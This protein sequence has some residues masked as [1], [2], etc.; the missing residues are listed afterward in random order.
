[1]WALYNILFSIG[2]LLMVPHFLMRMRRR[3]GYKAHFCN[4]F[5]RYAP[6]QMDAFAPGEQI[7]VHAVSVGEMLVALRFVE[8]W[9]VNEA[10][11]RFVLST[12]TS[13]GHALAQERKDS[14]DVL[15]YYPVDFPLYVRRALTLIQPRALILVENEMW[16]NMVRTSHRRKIP[17]YLINGRISDRSFR[18][19][20][21]ARWFVS[22]MLPL[23]KTLYVQS[24]DDSQRLALL[25]APA[26][27]LR[28]VGSVKYDNASTE[29]SMPQEIQSCLNALGMGDPSQVIVGGSTWPG[30]ERALVEAFVG[31]RKEFPEVKLILVPRHMEKADAVMQDLAPFQLT[32]VRRTSLTESGVMSEA[33]VLVVDTT[34]ELMSFY[35]A[36]DVVFVG[37]SLTE[38]GGQ[39]PIEPAALG[40]AVVVGPNMDNFRAVMT[41]LLRANAVMCVKSI[42]EL[43]EVLGNLI[44]D[45]E[46]RHGYGARARALVVEKRG[47]IQLTVKEI[48]TELS[49][50]A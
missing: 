10:D 21:K 35:G 11:A 47:A 38:S 3:G 14:R 19:Y 5:G 6:E 31:L 32:I 24:A 45:P 37:K 34:G 8:E 1:M 33:D 36:G 26:E 48:A 16:P 42:V 28:E 50:S 39:N 27:S 49:A 44:R 23:V 41:D 17:V 22:R 18:G 13:T 7:W 40:R 30:E 12:N 25:G 43:E 15:I 20:M 2:Y 29:V 4:R 46:L 9:R